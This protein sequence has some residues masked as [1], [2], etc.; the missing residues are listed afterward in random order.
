MRAVSV[1]GLGYVGLSLAVALA[2]RGFRVV[3]VDVDP[4]KVESVNS[5]RSPIEEPGVIE[6]LPR[7]VREG[8]V[9]A[10]RDYEYAVSETG[11]SL[12][13]VNTPPAPD[14]RAD[15]SQ[16]EAAVRSIGGALRG[17]GEFHLVVVCSTVPPGTT[18]G[19]VKP[20]LEGASGKRVGEGVGLAVMPEFLREGSAVEDILRPWRVVVGVEDDRSK[21]VVM[22]LVKR[23]YGDS[24]PPLV[25]TN[26][27]NAE[28]IKYASNAFLAT[29]VSFVNT[30]ARLCEALS[31]ADV[32]VVA[33][34]AGLDPRIGTSYFTA[35]PGYGGICLPKDLKALI[36]VCEEHGLDPV[37]LK[38]VDKVNEEQVKHVVEMTKMALG[39]LEGRRVGVLGLAFKAGT[40]DV[41][42]SPG[43]KIARRLAEKGASVKVYDP[44]ALDNARKELGSLVSY[45]RSALEAAEGCDA[46]VITTDDEEFAQLDINSLAKAMR[47]LIIIDTRRLLKNLRD[48]VKALGGKYYAIGLSEKS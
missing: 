31:G 36:K 37:L 5:G 16:L 48:Q 25:V 21:E 13:A 34:G 22:M 42:E 10:T 9:E 4:G 23:L 30:L 47:R 17:K 15:L 12:V 1:I 2:L 32:D 26:Y 28:L 20:L 38:A 18:G 40:D 44:L 8:L 29:R 3:G 27:V 33:Y 24:P 45:A 14:G 46:I 7:L 6:S 19:F 41:R 43:L 39:G 11:A 35:G